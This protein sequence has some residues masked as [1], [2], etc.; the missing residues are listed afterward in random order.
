MPPAAQVAR[1]A[2]IGRGFLAGH[3]RL[4]Q[5]QAFR[6]AAVGGAAAADAARACQS[7][8]HARACLPAIIPAVG[9][10]RSDAP[11]LDCHCR[12]RG[13]ARR[14]ARGPAIHPLVGRQPGRSAT[15]RRNRLATRMRPPRR[16][17]GRRPNVRAKRSPPRSGRPGRNGKPRKRH[18]ETR[19]PGRRPRPLP[20]RLPELSRRRRSH[21]RSGISGNPTATANPAPFLKSRSPTVPSTGRSSFRR[22]C[23]RRKNR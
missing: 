16:E 7:L 8:R 5:G 21:S 9:A 2:G 22:R 17:P 18:A 6:A 20:S 11:T 3:R 15:R 19:R 12:G 4:P 1:R 10:S 23:T 13:R 14:G